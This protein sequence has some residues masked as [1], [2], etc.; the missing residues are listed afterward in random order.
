MDLLH[1]D[2]TKIVPIISGRFALSMDRTQT[3]NKSWRAN[4]LGSVFGYEL[5]KFN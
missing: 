1:P 5:M 4:I 3:V 2:G